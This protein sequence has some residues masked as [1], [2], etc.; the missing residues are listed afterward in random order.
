MT[1]KQCGIGRSVWT[2]GLSMTAAIGFSCSQSP[3]PVPDSLEAPA[4]SDEPE[5]ATSSPPCR[6]IERIDVWKARRE[7][8]A[9]CERGAVLTMHV[10]IGRGDGKAK[11][12]SGDQRTPEGQYAIAGLPRA[13]RF[14]LFIPIDYP[15]PPDADRG[16]E[17]GLVDASIHADIVEAHS[18]G[19][20]PP[21]DTPL[22]GDIGLHGEGAAWQG[23]TQ[24]RDWTLGCIAVTDAEIEQ[25]AER[26]DVGV[27]V[28]IHP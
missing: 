4:R 12:F 21:Q 17:T 8:R 23:A 26:I 19:R 25:L 10:A 20:F 16:L 15:S 1:W 13:S 5:S 7:L 22:G 28:E 11:R 2:V 9:Q 14:H 6:T 27:P 18:Q 24:E 3:E